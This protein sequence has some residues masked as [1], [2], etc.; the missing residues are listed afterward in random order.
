MYK[1]IR[2]PENTFFIPERKKRLLVFHPAYSVLCI[3]WL[4]CLFEV[5]H[6][7]KCS[8]V[9]ACLF[10]SEIRVPN[11][12]S[13]LSGLSGR[14]CVNGVFIDDWTKETK[15]LGASRRS[16]ESVRICSCAID[17]DTTATS[18]NSGKLLKHRSPLSNNFEKSVSEP[19]CKCLQQYAGHTCMSSMNDVNAQLAIATSPSCQN[20]SSEH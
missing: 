1:I 18:F 20:S 19:F 16:L 4:Y 9:P 11:P 15:P 3:L 10:K 5:V 2:S 7:G 12:L 17:E 14:E 8:Q 6:S 13:K